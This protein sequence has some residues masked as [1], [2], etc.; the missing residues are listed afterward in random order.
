VIGEDFLFGWWVE[1]NGV[2]AAF[3]HTPPFPVTVTAMPPQVAEDLAG[4][5][6]AH[7]RFL[8]GVNAE[9]SAAAAFAATWEARTGQP[10]Q[11]SLHMRM[12]RLGQLTPPNPAPPG[13]ARLAAPA[14]K[15]LLVAWL[16]AFGEEA[17]SRPGDRQRK[18]RGR[19]P[20]LWRAHLL[21]AR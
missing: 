9:A 20:H 14:D 12:Y 8:V 2:A 15:D 5:L 19:P 21:G 18:I 6:A 11:V 4:T 16:A 10:S 7:G 3:M 17:G 13:R 1:P